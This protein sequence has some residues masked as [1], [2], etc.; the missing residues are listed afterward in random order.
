VKTWPSD[1]LAE[2]PTLE[3]VAAEDGTAGEFEGMQRIGGLE[4]TPETQK[5]LERFTR[6]GSSHVDEYLSQA[7][8]LRPPP[9]PTGYRTRDALLNFYQRKLGSPRGYFSRSWIEADEDARTVWQDAISRVE[10]ALIAR[11]QAEVSELLPVC[12]E[13]ARAQ[14]LK[15][16]SLTDIEV[17]LADKGD[18]LST[19][20]RKELWRRVKLLL[21]TRR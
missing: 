8:K 13:W 19:W 4:P 1:W 2:V 20:G 15:A 17:F 11:E 3:G 6:E 12:A 16:P 14:T 21:K 9:E 10:K 7:A 18:P 5:F